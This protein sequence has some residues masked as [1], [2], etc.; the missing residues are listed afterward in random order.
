[1]GALRTCCGAGLFFAATGLVSLNTSEVDAQTLSQE[2]VGQVDQQSHD[3][4]VRDVQRRIEELQRRLQALD[5]ESGRG[6]AAPSVSSA[7]DPS[8]LGDPQTLM[9]PRGDEPA[10]PAPTPTP[11]PT[12]TASPEVE[13]R[14]EKPFPAT[15]P[16]RVETREKQPESRPAAR[17]VQ[18]S[19]QEARERSAKRAQVTTGQQGTQRLRLASSQKRLKAPRSGITANKH[20]RVH[21]VAHVNSPT[22]G[23]FSAT[24]DATRYRVGRALGCF[25]KFSCT[26]RQVAGTAIGA[27]AGGAAGGGG[28][29]L[30]GGLVGAVVASPS[31]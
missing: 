30:A 14:T 9:A 5:D 10:G 25:V 20:R 26:S 2:P 11:T 15:D 21:R 23:G 22:L 12:V 8:P 19:E 4:A 17:D 29:A 3:S 16:L 13:P 1:M 24:M 27:A 18:P 31:R 7:F 28:G 6:S